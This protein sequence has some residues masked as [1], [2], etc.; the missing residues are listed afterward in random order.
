LA[1]SL[2]LP[3]QAMAG[4]GSIEWVGSP[5]SP[6]DNPGL[7]SIGL[8]ASSPIV[9]GSVTVQLT[10]STDSSSSYTIPAPL[11]LTSG[12]ATEG[13]WTV[14]SPITEPAVPLGQ[15]DLYVSATD[16]GGD[17]AIVEPPQWNFDIVPTVTLSA[18]PDTISANGETV[19]LSG[20]AT[21]VT[22]DSAQPQSEP[23]ADQ[24]VSIFTTGEA[25]AGGSSVTV[26]TGNDGSFSY[27][28]PTGMNASTETDSFV[29]EVEQTTTMA[30]ALSPSVTIEPVTAPVAITAAETP[31]NPLWG[32]EVYV[33]GTVSVEQDGGWQPMPYAQVEVS[34]TGGDRMFATANSS[35]QFTADVLGV[36][37]L[38]R[39][40]FTVQLVPEAPYGETA[41]ITIPVRPQDFDAT[42]TAASAS[43]DSYGIVH[44]SGCVANTTD[45]GAGAPAGIT[46]NVQYAPSPSGPWKALGSLATSGTPCGTNEA[47]SQFAGEL[48]GVLASAYYR[49][50]LGTDQDYFVPTASNVLRASIIPTRFVSFTATPHKVRRDATITVSGLLQAYGS[51]WRG[52]GR[53]WVD[54]IFLPPGSKVWYIVYRVRTSANGH[55]SKR[56]R[57]KF[58]SA[59]WSADYFGNSTHLVAGAAT[60][61]IRVT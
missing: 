6:A 20:L 24:A 4:S 43:I 5:T 30:Q 48:P 12:T 50:I 42:L 36:L 37:D 33:T 40:P 8:E 16:S 44:F 17:S 31:P 19:T 47:S 59:L 18:T 34:D 28:T 3:A 49:A 10:S 21:A 51:A 27:S 7:L 60:V 38:T 23:L 11:V 22:P 35:G 61:R 57:D 58:G 2:V 29:A 14:T 53:Q 41:S 32:Q 26:P 1:G 52:Y 45:P 55:F 46:V 15:Y 13:T 9:V 54:I 39:S 25:L 56:F